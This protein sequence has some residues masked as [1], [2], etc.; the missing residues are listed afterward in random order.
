[1][2]IPAAC[3]EVAV[4][5]LLLAG[6]SQ[7]SESGPDVGSV[8]HPVDREAEKGVQDAYYPRL[9]QCLTEAG[10]PAT[11]DPAEGMM[12]VNFGSD[13]QYEAAE[14]AESACREQLGPAPVQAPLGDSEKL[15]LYGEYF[16]AYECLVEQGYQPKEPPSSQ[17]WLSQY[18]SGQEGYPWDDPNSLEPF[19]EDACPKPTGP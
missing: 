10:F 18:G 14:Q 16:L 13:D 2:R 5:G 11:Y 9:A 17:V 12:Q 19:P 6:C 4:L 8:T 1:M 15:A 7:G 3:L